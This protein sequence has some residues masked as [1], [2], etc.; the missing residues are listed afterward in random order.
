MT[1]RRA[2]WSDDLIDAVED[3]IV[4]AMLFIPDTSPH[5]NV[6][7]AAQKAA[8]DVIAAVEDW[9]DANGFSRAG[10]PMHR[11]IEAEAAIKKARAVPPKDPYRPGS[12]RVHYRL[13]YND[14]LRDVLRAIDGGA[15]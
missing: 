13:G 5:T 11:L 8:Y 2:H 3:R 15:E 12:P 7:N 1:G 4:K 9:Q 6:R 10:A 14:A